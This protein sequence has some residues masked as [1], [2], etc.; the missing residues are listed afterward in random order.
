MVDGSTQT[1]SLLKIPPKTTTMDIS[2]ND[3]MISMESDDNV[4]DRDPDW[5]PDEEMECDE[6][7][8]E[9]IVNSNEST[10]RKYLLSAH[11][12]SETAFFK[13]SLS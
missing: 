2:L 12:L 3:S 10:E 4:N 13:I 6:E 5:T 11:H 7:Y 9:A 8:D 1:K